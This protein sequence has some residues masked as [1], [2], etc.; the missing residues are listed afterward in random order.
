MELFAKIRAVSRYGCAEILT[1]LP[2]SA[3]QL[4]RAQ[5]QWSGHRRIAR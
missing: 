3:G 1:L 2:R 5:T 4:S